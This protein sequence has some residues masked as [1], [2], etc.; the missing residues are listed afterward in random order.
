MINQT[1]IPFC[2][3]P[4]QSPLSLLDQ[5]P[6]SSSQLRGPRE[7]LRLWPLLLASLLVCPSG[8]LYL[9]LLLNGTHFLSP[10]LSLS[11]KRPPLP[12]PTPAFWLLGLPRHVNSALAR[13]SLSKLGTERKGSILKR[14]KIRIFQAQRLTSKSLVLMGPQARGHFRSHLGTRTSGPVPPS[15]PQGPVRAGATCPSRGNAPDSGRGLKLA[16]E[17]KFSKSSW[18]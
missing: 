17:V 8:P 3:E 9:L 11:A 15:G 6:Q 18:S 4:S 7:A 12:P 16:W 5:N 13:T 10:L 14:V 1:S 2:S